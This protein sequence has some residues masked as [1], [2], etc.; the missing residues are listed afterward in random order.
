M[1]QPVYCNYRLY[2]TLSKLSG[3]MQIDLVLGVGTTGDAY[4]RQAHLRPISGTAYTPVVDERIMDRP[5]QNNIKQFY[6]KTKGLFYNSGAPAELASDW[7]MTVSKHEMQNLKYIKNWDD[8]FYAGCQR[9]SYKLY[10]TTHEVLVPVWLDKCNGVKFLIKFLT[11]DDSGNEFIITQRELNISEEYLYG[12]INGTPFPYNSAEIFHNDFTKY[13]MDYFEYIR[14]MDGNS[15]VMNVQ[16]KTGISTIS[17]IQVESGNFTTRQN[18]NIVKNLM[19]RERPLLEAN[20]LLT[21]TFIDY[22]MICSQLINFNLCFDVDNML[23]SPSLG[24]I[25]AGGNMAIQVDVLALRP[26]SDLEEYFQQSKTRDDLYSFYSKTSR[27][28]TN[29]E[30]QWQGPLEIRDFYTNHEYVPR[31]QVKFDYGAGSDMQYYNDQE[32]W[33]NAL[34]YKKDAQS[35]EMMHK[36]KITQNICHWVYAQQPDG[37]LFNVYD[38]FGAYAKDGDKYIIY[39]HGFGS[40]TDTSVDEFDPSADNTIW[41]GPPRIGDGDDIENTLNSTQSWIENGY[42]KDASNFIGGF[43]FGF[44]SK[45]ENMPRKLYIGTMATPWQSNAEYRKTAATSYVSSRHMIGILIERLGADGESDLP[46]SRQD[47][48]TQF[49]TFYDW[50]FHSDVD[51]RFAIRKMVDNQPQFLYYNPQKIEL[52]E[53]LKNLMQTNPTLA[54]QTAVEQGIVWW[55]TL[56]QAEEPDDK[57]TRVRVGGLGQYN[58]SMRQHMNSS[59]LYIAMRRKNRGDGKNRSDDD[60]CVILY[61]PRSKKPLDET[62]TSERLLFGNLYPHGL[63]I[64]GFINAMKDYCNKYNPCMTAIEL[65][66]GDPDADDI[67]FPENLPNMGDMNIV[68]DAA[69]SVEG[70]EVIWFNKSIMP[71]ADYT[72]SRN[73][74]EIKYYKQDGINNYVLRYSGNIKPAMFPEKIIRNGQDG[75]KET[76]SYIPTFGRNFGYMKQLIFPSLHMQTSQRLYIG[77]GVPPT[78]PSLGY[79]SIIPMIRTA[80]TDKE[81]NIIKNECKESLHGDILYNEPLPIFFGLNMDGSQMNSTLPYSTYYMPNIE[82]NTPAQDYAYQTY[83]WYEYKWFDKS[84]FIILPKQLNYTIKVDQNDSDTLERIAHIVMAWPDSREEVQTNGVDSPGADKYFEDD[85]TT[86]IRKRYLISGDKKIST[87]N[88][89]N[90]KYVIDSP[91]LRNTY[92]LEFNLQSA[93]A[94]TTETGEYIKDPRT[95][96]VLY[97]YIYELIATLK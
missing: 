65:A 96:Q 57:Y 15:S 23:G 53:E 24:D 26:R 20:S 27:N 36:N 89:K 39:D 40:T 50:H 78:Y 12:N 25:A 64:G 62:S 13:L 8:T 93:K 61:H 94:K 82:S 63:T 19:Y 79:E 48:S 37:N 76:L 81:G 86:P 73:S 33:W 87:I 9:M 60:L 31:P 2:K 84:R 66:K 49:D 91:Y 14:M 95:N 46:K 11:V 42:F 29:I 97:E 38:G 67:R 58:T 5:H 17:G 88:L 3:N 75:E 92:D 52:S 30:Y 90:K 56:Q 70:Q 16:F 4:V 34:D 10:G 47:Q 45:N 68:L 43:K 1:A 18:Y 22:K 7:F 41:A 44:D 35:T 74:K 77:T 83:E 69:T 28:D 80:A 32:Y 59:A 55:E 54:W 6:D 51:N 72:L 85:T 21:N 71:Q